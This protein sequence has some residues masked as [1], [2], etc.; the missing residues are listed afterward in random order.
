EALDIGT[1]HHYPEVEWQAHWGIAK[2]LEKQ[3]RIDNA[4][5]HY[6]TSLAILDSM[7]I[8]I[9]EN[10]FYTDFLKYKASVYISLMQLLAKQ[11]RLQEAFLVAQDLKS[12]AFFDKSDKTSVN[13][14]ESIPESLKVSI[15]DLENKLEQKHKVLS[16]ELSKGDSLRDVNKL[17]TFEGEITSLESEKKALWN[18]IKEANNDYYQ[19]VRHEPRSIRQ[20]QNDFLE[21]QQAIVEYIVG[22]NKTSVFIITQNDFSY[23]EIEVIRDSLLNAFQAISPKFRLNTSPKDDADIYFNA[24]E[25]G[26]SVTALYSLFQ[27]IFKP[28]E[29]YLEDV[30]ELIVI[31]DDFLNYIP[32]EMLISDTSGIVSDYDF[33]KSKYLLHDFAIS[34]APSA[35]SLAQ[36]R[37]NRQQQKHQ[38]IAFGNPKFDKSKKERLGDM[39]YDPGLLALVRG[40]SLLP[41]PHA[42]DE[43]KRIADILNVDKKSIFIGSG[44]QETIVKSTIEDSQIIHFAT[45]HLLNDWEP[46]YSKMI[47]AQADNGQE[48]GFLHTYE[49][50]NLHLNAD[51][52]VLSACNTGLGR[53]K[54]GEG[55]TSLARAFLYAGAQSLVASLWSVNDVSTSNIMQFFYRNLKNGVKKNMAL[56]Q[57]KIEYI[58]SVGAEKAD[59]FYWAPFILIGDLKTIEFVK[60]SNSIIS[61]FYKNFPVPI[62]LAL[63]AFAVC[64]LIF[65]KKLN[66][67]SSRK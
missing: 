18:K 11:Q 9:V 36:K 32:F 2:A 66:D 23:H 30:K 42:E 17:I 40:D 8:T 67:S 27:T 10:P 53:I 16:E 38:L 43:V 25:M 28:I 24:R 56:Q 60:D 41:L 44:A 35:G 39:K 62:I 64:L 55:L 65:H 49:I 21:D 7:R 14:I 63:F 19:L 12:D 31:P 50:F 37:P 20:I 26:F 45:H 52:V 47:L 15:L 13:L 51:L 1:K 5:E 48:D 57:A 33:S 3:N 58:N 54:R 4:I 6:K 59:P 46:L 34:Y 61:S 29:P 22:M